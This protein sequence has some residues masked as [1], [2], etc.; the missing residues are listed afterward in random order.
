MNKF[1]II[2]VKLYRKYISPVKPP[3]CRFYPTCSEYSLQA[4]EKYGAKKG[5]Y[6]SIKRILKCHP[7]NSGGYDPLE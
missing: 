4:L 3:T 7:F 5:S 1:L 2:I 6:L